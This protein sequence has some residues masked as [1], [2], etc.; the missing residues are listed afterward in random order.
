M[1]CVILRPQE[2][3]RMASDFGQLLL[4]CADFCSSYQKRWY[5]ILKCDFEGLSSNSKIGGVYELGFD[6]FIER[7]RI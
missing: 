6:G 1:D 5:K 3:Q 2:D 7:L 4:K